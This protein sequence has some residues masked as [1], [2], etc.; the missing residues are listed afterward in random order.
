[1]ARFSIKLPNGEQL[2]AHFEEWFAALLVSLSEEQRQR[3]C[4]Q[5]KA[6]NLR[7]AWSTPG[8]HVLRTAEAS[9]FTSKDLK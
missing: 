7:G 9:F 8:S 1:M 4:D 2:T 3:V 5:L 6:N